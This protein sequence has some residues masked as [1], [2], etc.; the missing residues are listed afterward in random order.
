MYKTY[1]EIINKKS[2]FLR[3]EKDNIVI[4]D[5]YPLWMKYIENRHWTNIVM[6]FNMKHM[7]DYTNTLTDIEIKYIK[8]Q[9]FNYFN[10]LISKYNFKIILLTEVSHY[11]FDEIYK[12]C[13]K[14]NK[15]INN[16]FY[17]QIYSN[18]S[19][20]VL[21]IKKVISPKNPYD[22]CDITNN[23]N[24]K[25]NIILINNN[26]LKF[27][28]S[29]I[30]VIDEKNKSFS[31]LVV[32]TDNNNPNNELLLI[33]SHYNL[34]YRGTFNTENDSNITDYFL[35]DDDSIKSSISQYISDYNINYIIFGGDFNSYLINEYF[36]IANNIQLK[37]DKKNTNK[38]VINYKD[39]KYQYNNNISL[40]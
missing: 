6:T 28:T 8:E 37:Y 40:E 7:C 23:N 22:E 31:L 34:Y 39:D 26:F 15:L 3:E 27:N 10:S 17:G 1:C 9:K 18:T 13:S 16:I 4:F 19:F 24:Y 38:Y 14:Q 21:C 25:Y 35:S 36:K 30:T 32:C 20:D 33:C 12:N 29:S 5:H 2:N 11:I